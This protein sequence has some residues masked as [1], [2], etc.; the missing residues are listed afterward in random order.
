M[1]NGKD[2]ECEKVVQGVTALY[3]A[4][5]GEDWEVAVDECDTIT[6][7]L[8]TIL[9]GNAESPARK[10]SI[11]TLYDKLEI[12]LASFSVEDM[13][14]VL[15]AMREKCNSAYVYQK[16]REYARDLQEMFREMKAED[17]RLY[18]AEQ[19]LSA[20]VDEQEAG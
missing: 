17:A 2:Y 18:E 8:M 12:N 5:E 3:D 16:S 6:A 10:D 7:S 11:S 1:P 4:I 13:M 9:A 19:K 20:Q 15:E 14:D